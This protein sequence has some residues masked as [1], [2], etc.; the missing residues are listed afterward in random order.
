FSVRID[1]LTEPSLSCDI[2]GELSPTFLTMNLLVIVIFA[3]DTIWKNFLRIDSQRFRNFI[4]WGTL[5]L[6]SWIASTLGLNRYIPL[7]LWCARRLYMPFTDYM[8]FGIII[9]GII[10]AIS[11][12]FQLVNPMKSQDITCSHEKTFISTLFFV[13]TFQ[14]TYQT[15]FYV[16]LLI[17]AHSGGILNSILLSIKQH[18]DI[19][20]DDE[21][22]NIEKNNNPTTLKNINYSN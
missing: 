16:I 4:L 3:F 6:V 14:W 15:F 18:C 12:Y 21:I 10:S 9:T 22:N 20:L 8:N 19:D 5:F 13:Y 7:E 11:L 1:A 17:G 2:G